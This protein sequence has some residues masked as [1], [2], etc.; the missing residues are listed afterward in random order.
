MR[1]KVYVEDASEIKKTSGIQA[2]YP[3]FTT[4]L[5]KTTKTYSF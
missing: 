1:T 2:R 4:Y 3:R 5:S